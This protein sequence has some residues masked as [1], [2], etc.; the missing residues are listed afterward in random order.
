MKRFLFFSC[1]LLVGC[2]SN[3]NT[4]I[5]QGENIVVG[6]ISRDTIFGGLIKFYNK[7]TKKLVEEGMYVDGKKNGEYKRYYEN[8]RVSGD[9][10]FSDDKENGIVKIYDTSG[11]ILTQSFYYYGLRTGNSL[12]YI[13][14]SLKAYAFLSLDETRL[15]YFDYDSLK[16]KYLPD[17]TK[18]FFFYTKSKYFENTYDTVAK[19]TEYF[20]YTPNPPREEF[21]YSLV[22][23]DKNYKVVTTLIN[24]DK[25]L[26]WS[27]FSIDLNTDTS[28]IRIAIKLLIIDK[29]HENEIT[30]FKVLK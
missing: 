2:Y 3:S 15:L 21:N 10:F 5:I 11:K 7:H 19:K 26:P 1:T 22:R 8:G 13:N 17:L 12:K 29:I 4:S 9:L 28:E 6:N 18:D 23:I 20:L 27:R 24:F 30:T 25:Q 16:T 14:D